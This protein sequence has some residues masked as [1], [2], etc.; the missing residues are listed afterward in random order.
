[1][2]YKHTEIEVC[3]G[4]SEE[5]RHVGED[6]ISVCENCGVVEGYTE[7]IADMRSEEE[8]EQEEGA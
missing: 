4:C 8:S 5:V 6:G 1:M 2:K 7:W 3:N